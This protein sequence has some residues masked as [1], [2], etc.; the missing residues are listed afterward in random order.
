MIR[1]VEIKALDNG[2][3]RNQTG[4]LSN[5][6]DGWA[7]IP[8][9]IDT[10]NFPFGEIETKDEEVKNIIY[11]DGKKTEKTSTIKVVTKWTA[12]VIPEMEVSEVEKLRADIDFVA[13]MT[14]VEL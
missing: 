6:P 3:H 5:I 8:G 9:E 2:A 13:I 7:V 4:M 11:V 10:P 14:G 12:G 1:I